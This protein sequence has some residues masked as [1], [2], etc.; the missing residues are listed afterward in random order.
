MQKFFTGD[1]VK[2]IGCDSLW[3]N[4]NIHI[5]ENCSY[6]GNG[7]FTYATNHGAWFED[8]DFKL[9]KRAD[10]STFKDLDKHLDFY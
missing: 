5:I 1:K 6:E 9:I 4:Y 2:Y 8:S 10:K 7:E 3:K